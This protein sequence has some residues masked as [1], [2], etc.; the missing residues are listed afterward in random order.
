MLALA[1]RL[2]CSGEFAEAYSERYGR[3]AAMGVGDNA[4]AQFAR[5][6]PLVMR[7]R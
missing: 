5:K 1:M 4:T 2:Y 6:D 3:N 7:I